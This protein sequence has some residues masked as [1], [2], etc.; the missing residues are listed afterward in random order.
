MKNLGYIYKYSEDEKKG[1]IVYNSQ[2]YK[3]IIFND[4][5]NDCITQVKTGDIV[6]F[7]LYEMRASKIEKV[8]LTHFDKDLVKKFVH[9][10]IFWIRFENFEKMYDT[11][12]MEALEPPVGDVEAWVDWAINCKPPVIIPDDIEGLCEIFGKYKHYFNEECPWDMGNEH[13]Y[14]EF[15]SIGIF[16]ISLWVEKDT[17]LKPYFGSTKEEFFFLYIVMTQSEYGY[18]DHYINFYDD[19]VKIWALLLKQ[20][21]DD[22][23]KDI[24]IMTDGGMSNLVPD[25]F[26][27][28]NPNFLDN[29]Y[30]E[31]TEEDYR[32]LKELALSIIDDSLIDR[33]SLI[34]HGLLDRSSLDFD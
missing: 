34:H 6:Y 8:S 12:I 26:W 24:I 1:L 21:S 28:R 27:E 2:S 31:K 20:F 32:K 13:Y 9:D 15:L 23:L 30:G 18:S 3:A 4:N 33:S 14:E 19:N 7:D 29:E 16:N 11:E 5:D 17:L 25:D 10:K 22:D